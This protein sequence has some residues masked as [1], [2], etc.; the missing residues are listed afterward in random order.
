L[1]HE[2]NYERYLKAAREFD[3]FLEELWAL[4]QSLPEYRGSTTFFITVDHGRGSA[5]VVWKNHGKE[6]PQSAYTWFAVIGPDTTP[7]GERSDTCSRHPSRKSPPL[8][9]S[10]WT[11]IFPAAILKVAPP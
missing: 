8:L 5:P 4:A 9:P 6:I 11:K 7:L 2:D 1:A 10:L 3:R